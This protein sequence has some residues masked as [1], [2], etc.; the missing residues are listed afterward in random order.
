MRNQFDQSNLDGPQMGFYSLEFLQ[1][2]CFLIFLSDS[3]DHEHSIL[4]IHL[5]TKVSIL[6]YLL[7]ICY[8]N[9][10]LSYISLSCKNKLLL[11]LPCTHLQAQN[12]S[13]SDCFYISQSLLH[14]KIEIEL[15][16]LHFQ[17][18]NFLF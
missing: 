12:N 8:N 5:P 16:E 17:K 6:N 7:K 9:E 11:N 14:W 2:Y 3:Q 1:F 18:V 13:L 15:E 4:L 10:N